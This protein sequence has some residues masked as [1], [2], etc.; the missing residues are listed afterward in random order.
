MR[1]DKCFLILM[2]LN[3]PKEHELIK[4]PDRKTETISLS[5]K[6]SNKFLGVF[7]HFVG[8]A[9]K[10]LSNCI[11][12]LCDE[13]ICKPLGRIFNEVFNLRLVFI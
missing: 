3:F 2:T 8:L 9:L 11:L 6:E 4:I 10:G 5:C 7:D 12:K 13:A 1:I